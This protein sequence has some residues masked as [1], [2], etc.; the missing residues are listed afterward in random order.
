MNWDVGDL[1][2]FNGMVWEKLASLQRP[3]SSTSFQRRHWS[4]C[5]VRLIETQCFSQQMHPLMVKSE[6][7][8]E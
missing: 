5:A 8:H 4:R 1:I 2:V 3:T 6:Q 7:S